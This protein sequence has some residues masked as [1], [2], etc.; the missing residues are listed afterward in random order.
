MAIEPMKIAPNTL[1]NDEDDQIYFGHFF[2][3]DFLAEKNQVDLSQS[4]FSEPNVRSFQGKPKRFA[5]KASTKKLRPYQSH[6]WQEFLSELLEFKRRNGH[7]LVPHDYPESPTLARWVKRQRYQ[8]NQRQQ[9][10]K[11]SITNERIQ[12]LNNIGFV[13]DS[14][15]ASWEERLKELMVFKEM[16]GTCAVPAT[17]KK[18]PRLA[19]WENANEDNTDFSVKESRPTYPPNVFL[20]LKEN[21]GKMPTKT[22]QTF[23]EG[24][25]ANIS[26][27][28]ILDLKRLGFEW[29]SKAS[30]K[31]IIWETEMARIDEAFESTSSDYELMLDVLSILSDDDDDVSDVSDGESIV[32]S[33]AF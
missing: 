10:K 3:E 28:R 12:I 15:E 18:N 16:H 19:T 31:L 33:C 25:P 26:A 5:K 17:Y 27:E 23:R 32:L 9:G 1:V 4:E 14:H 8:H 2:P 20:T 22:I 7:C 13:W 11:S 29:E 21:M 6:K 30:Q 24:K